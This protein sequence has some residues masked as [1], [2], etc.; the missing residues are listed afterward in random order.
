M[1]VSNHH[2]IYILSDTFK[3]VITILFLKYQ[4]TKDIEIASFVGIQTYVEENFTFRFKHV[5]GT[6]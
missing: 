1:V 6:S 2:I 5:G 3:S 4:S